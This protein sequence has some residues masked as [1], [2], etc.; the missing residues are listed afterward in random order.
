[1]LNELYTLKVISN[2]RKLIYENNK[3]KS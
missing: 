2:K 3:L 1:V